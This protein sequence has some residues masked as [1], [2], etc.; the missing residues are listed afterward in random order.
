M[1]L[2]IRLERPEDYQEVEILTRE[3]FWGF[4]RPTCDEH[5]LV[6]LLRGSDVFIPELDFVAESDNKIIG[7]VMY[8]K[9]KVV[10][11]NGNE[12]EIITF[13]PLSVLPSYWHRGVGS[14][15]MAHSIAEAKRL[16]YTGIVLHGHPDYY[17]RFG[18]TNAK[19]YGITSH[20]GQNYDALMAMPLYKGAFDPMSGKFYEDSIFNIKAEEAVEYNKNFPYKAPAQMISINVLLERLPANAKKAFGERNIT[21]LAWLNRLSGREMLTWDGIDEQVMRTINET[22]REYGYSEKLMPDSKIITRWERIYDNH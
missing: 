16:G 1:N 19:E 5:Y 20:D 3:A 8:S 6:H 18:F 10:E 15:L 4:T 2:S 21:V 13:G 14:A 9:A 12:H 22:L 7:N 11:D 17:P